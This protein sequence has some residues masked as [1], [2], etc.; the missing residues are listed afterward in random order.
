MFIIKYIILI[1]NLSKLSTT[2]YTK[3]LVRN[4]L[5]NISAQI[6]SICNSI[7]KHFEMPTLLFYP[8]Y[9]VYFNQLQT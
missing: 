8:L 4:G 5:A 6:K 2:S 3:H 9:I 7:G 1:D